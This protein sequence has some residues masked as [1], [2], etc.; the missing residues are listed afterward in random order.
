MSENQI[1][2]KKRVSEHGEVFTATREVK[3]MLDMVKSETER[4][5]S[6][7]LEPAC[8]EGAFL[9]EVLRRKL[10]I[11]K[12]RYKGHELEKYSILALSSL[13]GIDILEDNAIIC[14]ENLYN[15]WNSFYAQNCGSEC[16]DECRKAAL[17]I[18]KHNILY[19]NALT[20]LRNDGHPIVFAQWDLIL[21]DQLKRADYSLDALME[22]ENVQISFTMT[23]WEY[24]DELKSFIPSPIKEYPPCEYWKVQNDE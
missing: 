10:S 11:V 7:F 4:I 20:M 16:F 24:D 8:G 2:S 22:A 6:R 19:G 3:A 9:M 14:R 23:G 15:I 1:K 12:K 5:E 21:G 17:Y 13:Y 18:L